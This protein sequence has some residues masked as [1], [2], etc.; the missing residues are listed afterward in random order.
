MFFVFFLEGKPKDTTCDFLHFLL[1]YFPRPPKFR[2]NLA[3]GDLAVNGLIGTF[4]IMFL[5]TFLRKGLVVFDRR[6]EENIFR[7]FSPQYM[8]L[9]NHIFC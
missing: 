9:Q 4:E 3:G 1:K 7:K 8:H 6:K 2:G 5:L